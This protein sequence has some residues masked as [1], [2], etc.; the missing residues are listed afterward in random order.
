MF[1]DEQSNTYTRGGYLMS[2][3]STKRE[4]KKHEFIDKELLRRAALNHPHEIMQPYDILVGLDG[5]DAI[6]ALS[7]QVGGFTVYIPSARTIFS[8]CLE[9]EARKEYNGRNIAELAR[10]YGCT[11]RHMR[12]VVK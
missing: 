11:E 7:E 3:K 12:R 6:C 4:I 8:K 1:D 2:T 5:F 9:H 10:R